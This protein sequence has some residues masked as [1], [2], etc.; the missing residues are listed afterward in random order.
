MTALTLIRSGVFGAAAV[1]GPA[2]VLFLASGFAWSNHLIVLVP[3]AA[4]F[5]VALAGVAA[6]AWACVRVARFGAT[7]A[8]FLTTVPFIAL[9][10]LTF[11]ISLATAPRLGL[12]CVIPVLFWAVQLV[13]AVLVARA[14]SR[15][16]LR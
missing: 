3:Y 1:A 13:G 6:M 7:T 8:V 2:A 12:A 9:T 10:V 15:R 16:A 5:G 14:A 11:L 4:L